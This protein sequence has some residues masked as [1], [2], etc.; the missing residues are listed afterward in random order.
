MNLIISSII[1]YW[2]PRIIVNFYKSLGNHD[3]FI[4]EVWFLGI[5]LVGEYLNRV[6]FQVSTQKYV[7]MLINEVRL[8]SYSLWLKAPLKKKS[9]KA[10]DDFPLGEVLARLMSDTDSV[11]EIVTSGSFG[12]FVDIIFVIS[13]LIS[14]LTLNSKTGI[15]IFV[16]ELV[17]IIALVKGSKMMGSVFSEVRKITGKLARELTDICSGLK[18]LAFTPNSHYALKRGEKISEEFLTKQLNANIWDAS[19]YSAAESL[20]PI[21]IALVMILLP[22]SKITEIALLAALIDLIQRSI[23]PIKEIASKVSVIARARTGIERVVQFNSHF[24]GHQNKLVEDFRKLEIQ[25]F[26]FQLN[27]F[28]YDESFSLNDIGFDIKKGETLGIVGESGCGKSTLLKLL[29]G[30]NQTYEGLIKTEIM[31]LNPSIES[32]LRSFCQFVSLVSQDSH[33]FTET[34]KFNITLGDDS[35]FDVFWD[36]A[37]SSIPYL[38]RFH[39]EPLTLIKSKQISMGQKQLISGLRALYLKKPII[40]MDEL[41]SGLDSDLESALRDLILFI[42]KNCILIIVTHRLET[43]INANQLILLDKGRLV[44]KGRFE[45]LKAIPMFRNFIEH[46]G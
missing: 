9:L 31:E 29:C 4:K 43:I 25:E 28:S 44:A 16:A 38:D 13:S 5:V 14:F 21:L 2:T 18:D 36:K 12:I 11:R 33:V 1:G 7:Q 35:E 3:L 22:Y 15:F 26:K 34:L 46:L 39:F 23:N 40:L 20:Y 24:E 45:D 10:S 41:S 27:H 37:R 8:K 32:D 30:Q 6:I 17:A 19:Y 42:K